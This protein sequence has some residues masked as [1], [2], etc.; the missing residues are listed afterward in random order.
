MIVCEGRCLLWGS[1]LELL[2][3]P[4]ST[5]TLIGGLCWVMVLP[6]PSFCCLDPVSGHLFV[7][8]GMVLVVWSRIGCLWSVW[9]AGVPGVLGFFSPIWC[10]CGLICWCLLDDYPDLLT[11]LLV[12]GRWIAEDG[13]DVEGVP[14]SEPGLGLGLFRAIFGPRPV[15]NRWMCKC[16]MILING[17]NGNDGL[18]L[19][20]HCTNA[21]TR[22]GTPQSHDLTINNF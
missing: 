15:L 2:R 7:Q 18:Y 12:V 20:W 13:G 19:I 1:D 5:T 3:W 6:D 11:H 14:R 8:I 21:D 10:G 9:M 17:L 22:H 16:A 4:D